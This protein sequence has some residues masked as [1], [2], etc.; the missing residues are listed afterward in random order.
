MKQLILLV[1]YATTFLMSSCQKED[2]IE[3]NE[4]G[5]SGQLWN[6]AETA[7]ETVNGVNLILIFDEDSQSFKGTIENINTNIAQQVKVEVHVVYADGTT[8]E[9]GPTIPE[10]MQAGEK[11]N[12]VLAT[13]NASNFTGFRMH[14][15][16]GGSCGESEEGSGS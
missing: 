15:E 10:D 13:P 4:Q 12:V 1:V 8:K 5:E 9:Y 16:L 7:N 2:L 6:R 3:L 14:P 11:R